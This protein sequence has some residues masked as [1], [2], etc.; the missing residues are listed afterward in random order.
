M[1]VLVPVTSVP[2][3]GEPSRPLAAAQSRA[4]APVISLWGGVAGVWVCARAR[5]TQDV[6][7]GRAYTFVLVIWRH[8]AVEAVV[9]GGRRVGPVPEA[10]WPPRSGWAGLPDQAPAGTGWAAVSCSLRP[11]KQAGRQRPGT[12]PTAA[13]QP[14]KPSMRLAST[15]TVPS[16]VRLEPFPALVTGSSCPCGTQSKARRR[17]VSK[18]GPWADAVAV[19]ADAPPACGQPPRPPARLWRPRGV[20]PRPRHMQPGRRVGRRRHR[21]G[22]GSL[23]PLER[24]PLPTSRRSLALFARCHRF[25]CCPGSVER[26]VHSD[27]VGAPVAH[28]VQ[29]IC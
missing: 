7:F 11:V 28:P 10:L 2:S 22:H 17:S 27:H 3:G 8:T 24:L 9:V 16:K 21:A 13:R 14:V 23:R 26:T 6:S 18:R 15:S 25:Y 4:P 19:A 1:V 5:N 29:L 12:A 20:Q